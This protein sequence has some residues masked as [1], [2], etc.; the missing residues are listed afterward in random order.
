MH[1]IIFLAKYKLEKA[2]LS[3]DYAFAYTITAST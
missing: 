2:V 1:I 3:I